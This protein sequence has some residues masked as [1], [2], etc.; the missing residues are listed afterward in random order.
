MEW[1]LGGQERGGK[2]WAPFPTQG[3]RQE[4]KLGELGTVIW[5]GEDA[6]SGS[7]PRPADAGDEPTVGSPA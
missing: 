3:R 5:Q 1:A 7:T 2:D 6:A 4:P